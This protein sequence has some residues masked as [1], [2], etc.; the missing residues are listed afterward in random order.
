MSSMAL[1]NSVDTNDGA[2]SHSESDTRNSDGSRSTLSKVRKAS[3]TAASPRSRTSLT[4]AAICSR[5]AEEITLFRSR[6]TNASRSDA[7]MVD[8]S[9]MRRMEPR[10][11]GSGYRHHFVATVWF[12]AGSRNTTYA[13]PMAISEIRL[14]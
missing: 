10:D 5:N 8:H 14:P 7:D 11:M 12:R 9:N 6:S 3:H 2:A 13:T 1:T 4:R